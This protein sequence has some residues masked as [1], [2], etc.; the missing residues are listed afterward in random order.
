MQERFYKEL[1]LALGLQMELELVQTQVQVQVQVQRMVP[2][3]ELLLTPERRM[4]PVL[5]LLL[6][7]VLS[8]PHGMR[9]AQSE[10]QERELLQ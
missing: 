5:E 7:P 1:V 2:L 10:L 9:F 6:L 4:V 8:L 3:L